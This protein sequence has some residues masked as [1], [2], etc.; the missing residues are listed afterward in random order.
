M[1]SFNIDGMQVL[2]VSGM[3]RDHVTS[4]VDVESFSEL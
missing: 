1:E 2:R 3:F 4:L